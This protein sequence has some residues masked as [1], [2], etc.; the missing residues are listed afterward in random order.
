MARRS[1]VE[2]IHQ[3][4]MA[5]IVLALVAIPML[6]APARA[7]G[8]LNCD[9]FASQEEAQAELDRTYPEDPNRID[10]DEDGIA[11]ETEFGLDESAPARDGGRDR[12]DDTPVPAADT[13]DPLDGPVADPV[14]VANSSPVPTP[15]PVGDRLSLL[16]ADILARVSNCTVVA[17]SR[18][19]VAAAGC[20]GIGSLTLRIPDDAPPLSPTVVITPGAALTS[21]RQAGASRQ[22]NATQT[23]HAEVSRRQDVQ[24]DDNANGKSHR[25]HARGGE[26]TPEVKA[27]RRGRAEGNRRKSRDSNLEETRKERRRASADG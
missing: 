20:P 25:H 1:F 21:P 2:R 3:I 26:T 27:D 9:D 7:Q 6:D 11:C 4:L 23:A 15:D 10:S 14:P 8:D 12:A 22:V 18:R 16:P 17:V 19:G 24:E 13:S 5:G